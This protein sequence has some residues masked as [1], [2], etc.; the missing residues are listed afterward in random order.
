[1]T[2]ADKLLLLAMRAAAL[3]RSRRCSRSLNKKASHWLRSSLRWCRPGSIRRTS[4]E[5]QIQTQ[6]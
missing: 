1:M 5:P 3:I 2:N 6:S 4:F